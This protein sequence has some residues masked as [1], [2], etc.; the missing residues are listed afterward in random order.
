MLAED[1]ELIIDNPY[2]KAKCIVPTEVKN[3]QK[4]RFDYLKASE[5]TW[6]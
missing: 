1:N 6:Y 5:V 3:N 2:S 4:N